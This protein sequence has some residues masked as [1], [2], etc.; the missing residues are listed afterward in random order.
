MRWIQDS[1]GKDICDTDPNS[2]FSSSWSGNFHES[3]TL[4]SIMEGA[5]VLTL[6]LF[7]GTILLVD[8]RMLGLAFRKVPFSRLNAKVLPLT[9]VGFAMMIITGVLL[10]LSKPE[11]YYHNPWFRAKMAFLAVASINIFWFHFVVQKDEEKWDAMMPPP[12]KVRMSAILSLTCWTIIICFG[13]FIPYNWFE[14][15]RV[16]SMIQ[17]SEIAKAQA[18]GK[19]TDRQLAKAV[20]KGIIPTL[21]IRHEWTFGDEMANGFFHTLYVISEYDRVRGPA[22]TLDSLIYKIEHR[23]SIVGKMPI[24]KEG[25]KEAIAVEQKC[26]APADRAK[27]EKQRIYDAAAADANEAE[28]AAAWEQSWPET[29]RTMKAEKAWNDFVRAQPSDKKPK[30]EE[31]D[32]FIAKWIEQNPAL[33]PVHPPSDPP[34]GPLPPDPSAEAEAAE[35]PAV[36]GAPAPE[37]SPSATAPATKT[38]AAAT[39]KTPASGKN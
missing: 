29:A 17:D 30:P 35:A 2:P 11:D 18:Q 28:S 25:E 37:A 34:P 26:M 19:I 20:D 33:E 36:D 16:L 39:P 6:C 14:P 7:A 13:R 10:F 4:W 12:M 21:P 22:P 1:L 3:Q 15:G 32:P 38:P 27:A 9:I 24:E 23:T 31:H 8:L 5:H